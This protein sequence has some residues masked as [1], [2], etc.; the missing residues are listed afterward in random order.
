MYESAS[1]QAA[2]RGQ[3]HHLPVLKNRS[4]MI[5]EELF[6]RMVKIKY[7]DSRR[8][9]QDFLQKKVQPDFQAGFVAEDLSIFWKNVIQNQDFCQKLISAS[10]GLPV[11]PKKAIPSTLAEVHFSKVVS[12]L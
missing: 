4:M 1:Q 6:C 7:E 8:E 5:L 3:N 2:Y 10:A 12:V 9:P 11:L